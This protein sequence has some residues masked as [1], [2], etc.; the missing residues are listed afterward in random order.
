LKPTQYISNSCSNECRFGF[1]GQEKDQEIYNNQSTTTATFWE[2]DGRIGRRWNL[3]PKPQIFISDF[4]CFG[5]NPLSFSDLLGDKFK[6]SSDEQT[7][8]T[9]K[10]DF[11]NKE[12]KYKRSADKYGKKMDEAALNGDRKAEMEYLS[13]WEE[14]DAGVKEMQQAQNE[15]DELGSSSEVFTFNRLSPISK[16][17]F[18][19][20][21]NEGT[22]VINYLNFSNKVH[23]TKHAFQHI[24]GKLEFV[25]GGVKYADLTDEVEAY[26]RQFYYSS[27]SMPSS[28]TIGKITSANDITTQW[29]KGIYIL[30]INGE[31]EPVYKD[32]SIYF[33]LDKSGAFSTENELIKRLLS[34]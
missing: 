1:N 31:K 33:R 12:N 17:G 26:K 21:D 20:K 2:Y 10:K 32:Y 23:E 24:A 22:I 27:F 19:N 13:K 6:K 14:A 8:S 4:A 29:V 25:D 7:A 15:I 30:K 5:N 28:S 3:D 9:M 18:V 34:H 16:I 11:K